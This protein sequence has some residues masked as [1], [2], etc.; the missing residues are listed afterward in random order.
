[1]KKFFYLAVPICL[2]L[3]ESAESHAQHHHY[4][5]PNYE[6]GWSKAGHHPDHIVLN[7]TEDPSSSMSVT[8]RTDTTIRE[9]KA[10][11]AIAAAAPKFWRNA[12]SYSALTERMDAADV[13]GAGVISNYHSVTFKELISDTV[14]AYRVGDGEHWSEWFHFRTASDREQPFSFLYLGD[15]QNNILD[16]WARLIREGFRKAPEAGFIIHAGDLVND[17]HSEQEWHEWFSAG[18]F[19]HSMIPSVSTPGNHE[20]RP[21]TEEEAAQGIRSLS[22]QWR[23]QFT[24]PLNGVPGLEETA[25]YVDYQSCRI[26]SLNSNAD[27]LLQTEWLEKVLNENPRKWSIII[28]HHP[29]YSAS[30]RRDNPELREAWK[31]IFDRYHVDLVLQGHDHSYA[32]GKTMPGA[33]NLVDGVN[34]RDY[35]GTVYVVSVSG[36]KMYRLEPTG[37]DA[38]ENVEQDRNAENTQ[39]FQVISIDGDMLSYESYT[40][41]GELYDA[42]D[43]IKTEEGKPNR[44]IERKSEAIPARY[45]HN[46]IPYQDAE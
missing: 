1:M 31:P 14:Y 21:L 23:P 7:L 15:A 44:F 17:A 36:A 20:M 25:Y 37:W 26:I 27:P 35:A 43:L 38:F 34:T 28:F 11:I 41:T 30:A 5:A 33:E 39:L 13:L 42:F 32:R 12:V 24:L 4:Q 10:E 19:I 22:V 45:H 6:E 29:L 9:G 2:I 18:G 16:L 3:T 8:W 46:T 40:A